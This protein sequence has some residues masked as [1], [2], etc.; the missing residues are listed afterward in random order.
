M[1]PASH[2]EVPQGHRPRAQPRTV[3]CPCYHYIAQTPGTLSCQISPVLGLLGRSTELTRLTRLCKPE[4]AVLTKR[5]VK[6]SLKIVNHGH[7]KHTRAT[8]P[9]RVTSPKEKSQKGNRKNSASRLKPHFHT[10]K[11][12][13][14]C[15]QSRRPSL[16]AWSSQN[17][18]VA[19]GTASSSVRG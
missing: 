5:T 1:L 15:G 13:S 16:A 7:G 8:K 3:N 11:H 17:G 12:L 19:M 18:E 2:I 6:N 14:I 4:R 9:G 10:W